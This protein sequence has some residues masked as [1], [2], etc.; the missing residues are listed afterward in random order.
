MGSNFGNYGT[1]FLSCFHFIFLHFTFIRF[2]SL[3]FFWFSELLVVS[4]ILQ[5]FHL[6]SRPLSCLT[7]FSF[8]PARFFIFLDFFKFF[9][10]F[11]FLSY[12]VIGSRFYR[13]LSYLIKFDSILS[14]LVLLVLLVLLVPFVFSIIFCPLSL[15]S[16]YSIMVCPVLSC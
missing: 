8:S 13:I 2:F 4:F 3:L 16:S 7:Y 10:S 5:S 9:P 11:R 12:C 15:I 1:L 14:F 6:F